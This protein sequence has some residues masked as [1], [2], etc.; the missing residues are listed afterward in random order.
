[1]P[2]APEG[3]TNFAKADGSP[4]HDAGG[5]SF[6]YFRSELAMLAATYMY[7]GQ[8]EFGIQLVKNSLLDIV[9]KGYVWTQPLIIRGHRDHKTYNGVDYY[10]N[11]ILWV[12]PAAMAGSTLEG[13]CAPGGLVDRIIRAGKRA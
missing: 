7:Q 10:Q 8:R 2:L 11:L 5:W 1:M 9:K 6:N 13:P 4:A 12:L 3:I